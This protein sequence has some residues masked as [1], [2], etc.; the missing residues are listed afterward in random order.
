VISSQPYPRYFAPD[1]GACR[2][3]PWG[4]PLAARPSTLGIPGGPSLITTALFVR[5]EPTKP[6]STIFG[7][8]QTY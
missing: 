3:H 4:D 8:Y 2:P 1:Y 7:H 6:I 5:A